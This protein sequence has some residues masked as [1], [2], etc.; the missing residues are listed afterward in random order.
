MV[1]GQV[2]KHLIID[3]L[4]VLA[5]GISS[6]SIE[7]KQ[8]SNIAPRQISVS[9]SVELLAAVDK[10]NQTG[11]IEIILQAGRYPLNTTLQFLKPHISLMS[12]ERDPQKTQIIGV[13]MRQTPGV[14]NIIRVAAAHFTFDGMTLEQSPNHLIQIAGEANA[15]YPV[16][17]NCIMRDAYEQLVKVSHNPDTGIASDGGLIENC[18]FEYTAGIGPQYYIGG[19]DA[20][21]GQDWI[22]KNNY[23]YGIA[24]PENKIAEHAIHF[25]T[26]TQNISVIGNIIYNCDRGI[27]FG[28]P[29]RP[30]FG[31]VISNNLIV[32]NN[33]LHPNADTGIILEESRGTLVSGNRIYLANNYPNAIEYRFEQSVNVK[34]EHNIS[35]KKITKRNSAQAKLTGN[36]LT[37]DIDQVLSR[38]EQ[39]QFGFKL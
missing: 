3:A 6:P 15:D 9:N 37:A 26:N 5:I 13:G 12:T 34:I 24:S 8:L 16:L 29:R 32:H 4:L 35:N 19:I 14:N 33:K 21:G 36:I 23:F 39:Q 17:R 18:R 22:V 30:N 11:N 2:T 7:A 20:H 28:M 27:G 1:M 31:G 38:A 10:A 25:W